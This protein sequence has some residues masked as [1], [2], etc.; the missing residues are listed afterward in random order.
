MWRLVEEIYEAR[1]IRLDKY[2]ESPRYPAYLLARRVAGCGGYCR[3]RFRLLYCGP[4]MTGWVTT[5][6]HSRQ[7]YQVACAALTRGQLTGLQDARRRRPE[8]NPGGH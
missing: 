5:L 3:R 1:Y 2:R 8:R 4:S 6:R 7:N